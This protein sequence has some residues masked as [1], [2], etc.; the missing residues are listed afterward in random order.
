MKLSSLLG[1]LILVAGCTGMD[2]G[3][4]TSS[5]HTEDLGIRYYQ[6]APFLLVYSDGKGGIHHEI[7]TLPDLQRPMYA[8][9]YAW[10]AKNEVELTFANGVLQKGSSTGD[11]TALPKA[12]IS[13]IQTIAEASLVADEILDADGNAIFPSP[14]LFRVDIGPS[15]KITLR[16]GYTVAVDGEP[17]PTI[18]VPLRPTEE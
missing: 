8:K 14:Q 11:G 13:A 15:G 6:P 18:K 1:L 7:L 9:P 3:R 10:A 2:V 4:V 5:N 12:V 17:L 16:G